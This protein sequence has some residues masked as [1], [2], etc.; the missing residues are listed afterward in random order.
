MPQPKTIFIASS[1]K[2]KPLA[3]P[4]ANYLTGE[5]PDSDIREWY[6]QNTFPPSKATLDG[7]LAQAGECDF[8]IVLLTKDDFLDKAVQPIPSGAAV[9]VVK[10]VS[11][12]GNQQPDAPRDNTIF[13]LGMFMGA[14]GAERC[15]MVCSLD[16]NS[17]ALPSDLKGIKYYKIE[18]PADLRKI[19]ECRKCVK[20]AGAWIVD[21]IK[22]ARRL[23]RPQLPLITRADLAQ[24]ETAQ[25]DGN[26]LLEPDSVA[27]VV[28]SV[29]PVEYRDP[30]FAVTVLNNIKAGA[31]YEYFYGDFPNNIAA[32]TNLLQTLAM[33]EL[34][35]QDMP[36]KQRPQVMKEHWSAIWDNLQLMQE[37]LSIH[38]RK[39]PPLQFCVHNALSEGDAICYLRY[40]GDKFAK[41]AQRESAKAIAEELTSSCMTR[42]KLSCI[43]HSTVDFR[44]VEDPMCDEAVNNVIRRRRAQI[45]DLIAKRFPMD[46]P[47]NLQQDLEKIWL[48]A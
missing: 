20:L 46:L 41:W 13:E 3:K 40:D 34:M 19:E 11:G 33:A 8:A 29:E 18:P 5:L 31:K 7:L 15:F 21:I 1:G 27:V 42:D 4:L 12:K 17:N 39:R 14:L 10:D 35:L 24:L 22:Q 36:A 9:P 44:L 26:L 45:V 28:N 23:D 25:P 32:T 2:A 48:E 47:G 38:F 43:F 16:E 6:D 30:N 37:G